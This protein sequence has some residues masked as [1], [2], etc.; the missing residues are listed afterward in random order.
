MA[1]PLLLIPLAALAGY[2]AKK[3]HDG[4][5]HNREAELITAD[6]EYIISMAENNLEY[7]RTD[8]NREVKQFAEAKIRFVVK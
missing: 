3:V 1:F 5:N 7:A 8:A 6:T 4:Y 2:G